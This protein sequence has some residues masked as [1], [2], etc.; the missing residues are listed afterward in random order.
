MCAGV[1]PAT[2]GA[3]LAY[4]RATHSHAVTLIA[5]SLVSRARHPRTQQ[6]NVEHLSQLAV[7][8]LQQQGLTRGWN[9]W[10]AVCRRLARAREA[11]LRSLGFFEWGRS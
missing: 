5:I 1:E 3:P 9:T 11:Q 2:G 4:C 6:A 7:R 10:V 8:R